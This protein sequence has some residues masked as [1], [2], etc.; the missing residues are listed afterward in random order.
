M[1]KKEPFAAV[2]DLSLSL[3]QI[4]FNI[5]LL[6]YQAWLM[7]DAIVRTLFRLFV[8]HRHMLEWVTAA[9]AKFGLP[10]VPGRFHIGPRR[11]V[12]LLSQL[13]EPPKVQV[14][15]VTGAAV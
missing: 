2:K 13:D 15:R 6:A 12:R 10:L 7:A 4:G 1:K 14:H 3:S 5:A 9:Q 11:H 8:S